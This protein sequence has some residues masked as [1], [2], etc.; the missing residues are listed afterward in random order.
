VP[1]TRKV[2]FGVVQGY[3]DGPFTQV[4]FLLIDHP[5][6][7]CT[8]GGTGVTLAKFQPSLRRTVVIAADALD[9]VQVLDGVQGQPPPLT[10][11]HYCTREK[12]K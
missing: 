10:Y 1:Q 8:V 6:K 7:Q 4:V 5:F 3:A 11:I 2:V 12:T 9:P